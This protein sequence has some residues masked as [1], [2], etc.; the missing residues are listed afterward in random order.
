MNITFDEAINSYLKFVKLKNKPQSYRSIKSRLINY[1]LPYFKENYV[2][3]LTALQYLEWQKQIED[4]QF[5]YRY[6]KSLHYCMVTFLNFC[7]TFYDLEKNVASKVGNFKNNYEL[8]DNVN[9][10]TI[11][12]YKKFISVVDD[13]IYKVLFDL[14]YFTGCR[15]GE[16]LALTFNDLTDDVLYINKTISKEYYN[17]RRAITTP[18]TKKSIRK[19]HIDSELKV[20]I[21]QL[22]EY[23]NTKFNDF[24]NN[25]Y[26]FGGVKP[27]SP[28]TID[29]RKNKY[30]DIA[31]VK[32]IRIH[33]FRHSHASLLLSNNIPITAISNRLGHSDISMTLNIYLHLISEDEKRVL[34]TLNSLRLN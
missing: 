1:I 28:T 30:C 2:S 21:K 24:N 8:E 15:Q 14:L 4:K 11:Q 33:D 32:H 18:K 31:N 9:F 22:S 7:I 29:R 26:I 5:K 10:W 3:N 27:L 34:T 25:F 23:Y 19:I 6:K 17:G 12:E 13:Q 16:A 20:E